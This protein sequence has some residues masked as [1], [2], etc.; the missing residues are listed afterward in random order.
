VDVQLPKIGSK[1]LLLLGANVFKVL[2]TEDND[3]AFRDE[4]SQLVLLGICQLRQLQAADLSAHAGSQLVNFDTGIAS[5]E[6]VR[7]GLVC[8]VAAVVELEWL[9]GRV[10]GLVVIDWQV[11]GVGVLRMLDSPHQRMVAVA[12]LG[13]SLVVKRLDKGRH[14][15]ALLGDC[16]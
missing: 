13:V 16:D 1:L 9:C 15:L 10:F 7:L 14:G 2:V 8:C 11:A 4:Q 6:Q 5:L 12:Y 3:T